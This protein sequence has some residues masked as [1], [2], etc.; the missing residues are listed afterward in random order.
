[1]NDLDFSFDGQRVRMSIDEGGD[2]WWVAED[3]CKCL[4]I[5]RGRDAVRNLDSDEKGAVLTRTLGGPQQMIAVNEAGLYRLIF[6]SR[7]PEAQAFKRWIAHDVLPALRRKGFYKVEG[8]LSGDQ[9]RSAGARDHDLNDGF[10][11]PS[12]EN[13]PLDLS[14]SEW[15]Q[16]IR[17]TVQLKGKK[18]AATLLSR[19]PLPSIEGDEEAADELSGDL[20]LDAELSEFIGNCCVETDDPRHF[21][22]SSDLVEAFNEWCRACRTATYGK[23][24]AYHAL[25]RVI[26]HRAMKRSDSGYRGIVIDKVALKRAQRHSVT[27]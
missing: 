22:R 3:V 26:G 14:A 5:A 24:S 27:A 9:G 2:P 16:L 4:G 7:K 21:T 6:Q 8:G 23:R 17:L 19:S 20:R 10:E 25:K 1:M 18:V 15:I 13:S 12:F 11:A